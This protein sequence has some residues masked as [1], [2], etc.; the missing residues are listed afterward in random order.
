MLLYTV[1]IK[2]LMYQLLLLVLFHYTYF[3]YDIIG[4]VFIAAYY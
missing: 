3:I 1:H 2:Q 4:V